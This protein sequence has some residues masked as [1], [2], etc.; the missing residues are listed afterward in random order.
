M[1]VDRLEELLARLED[2]NEEEER[3]DVLELGAQAAVPAAPAPEAGTEE[4][5]GDGEEEAAL[6]GAGVEGTKVRAGA[7]GWGRDVRALSPEGQ[8]EAPGAEGAAADGA[9]GDDAAGHGSAGAWRDG[10][11]ALVMSSG[12]GAALRMPGAGDAHGAELAGA[13]RQAGAVE[14]NGPAG[15]LTAE[16]RGLEELYKQ[17]AR[18]G[19]PAAQNLPVEPAG[20]TAWAEEP[21]RTAALT[22]EELDRAVRRDSRRYDGGMT[23]F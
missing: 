10:W 15:S 23:L 9:G 3:E 8:A 5:A 16:E 2:E 1:L 14:T 6:A 11:A 21:G 17:T 22:V 7:L 18:A 13:E 20:R 4:A 12:G 19:R